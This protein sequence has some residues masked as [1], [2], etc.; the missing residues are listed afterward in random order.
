M[1]PP[2]VKNSAAFFTIVPTW[3]D[4]ASMREGEMLQLQ[5]DTYLYPKC[6]KGFIKVPPSM[7]KSFIKV[8]S[9]IKERDS[10]LSTIN[11]PIPRQFDPHGAGRRSME[12]RGLVNRENRLKMST[13]RRK[14]DTTTQV[15]TTESKQRKQVKKCPLHDGRE[16]Q[17]HKGQM[18]FP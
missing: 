10:D 8:C 15:T 3:G 2:T 18:A 1:T 9:S 4:R 13:P 5:R 14:G 7:H 16:I 6:I 17:Q 11:P 12:G